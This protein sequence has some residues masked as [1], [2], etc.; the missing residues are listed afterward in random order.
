MTAFFWYIEPSHFHTW[1]VHDNFLLVHKSHHTFIHNCTW[2]FLSVHRVITLPYIIVHE[3]FLLVHEIVTVSLIIVQD[4]FLL[5]PTIITLSFL[6]V[7]E[8]LLLT[9]K[10]ITLPH[11]IEHDSFLWTHDNFFYWVSQNFT[12][13]WTWQLF[14]T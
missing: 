5:V 3:S 1:F 4:S 9:Q 14:G 11:S 2:Q 12:Q 8:N 10:I 13:Q 6:N 7:H